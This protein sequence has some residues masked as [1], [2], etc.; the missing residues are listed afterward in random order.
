[1]R[2]KGKYPRGNVAIMT[3]VAHL[4]ETNGGSAQGRAQMVTG[5]QIRAARA[6]LGWSAAEL[7]EKAAISHSALQRAGD[8]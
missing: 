5:S 7:A 8:C 4:I 1:L 6:L 2:L 3:Q